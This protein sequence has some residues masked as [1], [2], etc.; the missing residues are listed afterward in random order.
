MPT[1]IGRLL[2]PLSWLG[3]A[4]R[5]GVFAIIAL[6][7]LAGWFSWSIPPMSAMEIALHDLRAVPR[8]DLV[9]HD[10][11]IVLVT[12]SDETAQAARRR[13]IDRRLLAGALRTIDSLHPRAIGIDIIFDQDE[14]GTDL[15]LDALGA[16]RTP[17]YLAFATAAAHP[18]VIEPWQEDYLRNFLSRASNERVRPMSVAL[19]VDDDGVIRRWP[20][21]DAVSRDAP[22]LLQALGR[23]GN[24]F[25][26]YEGPI[27]FRATRT[28]DPVFINLPV[29]TFRPPLA[30]DSIE[31]LRSLIAGRTIL[32]GGDYRYLDHFDTPMTRSTGRTMTGLEVQAHMLAQQLDD[33]RL[34]AFPDWA[35]WPAPILIVLAALLTA[36]VRMSRFVRLVLVAAQIGFLLA[37]PFVVQGWATMS[38]GMPALGWLLAWLAGYFA[39]RLAARAV[40]WEQ[41]R[42]AQ[43]ALHRYLPPEVAAQIL[44]R[45]DSLSLAGEKKMVYILF[46]DLEGFTTLCHALP[47]AEVATILNKYL[48]RL[49]QVVLDHGG[50]IDKFVGDAVIA[51]WGAPAT[52]PRGRAC[53]RL[54]ELTERSA[55]RLSGSDGGGVARRFTSGG[56]GLQ[57]RCG[58][59]RTTGTHRETRF[60]GQELPHPGNPPEQPD[61]LG[62]DVRTRPN[63]L[64]RA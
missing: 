59:A 14:P 53:R 45:P 5:V 39:A 48:E 47:A 50:T 24:G 63:P 29:E 54:F 36:A 30:R 51:L 40:R 32:I 61:Y 18:D 57:V 41:G 12:F 55:T 19:Q 27:A 64:G 22:P 62:R 52:D 35:K 31:R 43:S 10:D 34:P 23:R 37:V 17:T 1:A 15:L 60:N 7:L 2:K 42:L 4:G 28:G 6:G 13:Y 25:R 44:A 58:R 8:P 33:R 3:P 20:A 56:S 16:M 9:T 46:S 49:S 26:S 11:R 21:A 38:Y